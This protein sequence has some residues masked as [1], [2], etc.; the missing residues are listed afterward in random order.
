MRKGNIKLYGEAWSRL[1]VDY[2]GISP[3]ER[4]N[5]YVAMVLT[6]ISRAKCRLAKVLPKILA[7]D[8]IQ[9]IKELQNRCR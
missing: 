6:D 3:V 8:L 9:L 7:Y 4:W 5:S 1:E 2:T